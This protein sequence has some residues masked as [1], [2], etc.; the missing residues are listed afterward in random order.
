MQFLQIQADLN[1]PVHEEQIFT[2]GIL[3]YIIISSNIFKLVLARVR[4]FL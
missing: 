2:P 3:R 1:K 4:K